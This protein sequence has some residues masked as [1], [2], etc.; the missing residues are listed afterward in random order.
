MSSHVVGQS[1]EGEGSISAPSKIVAVAF[2][3]RRPRMAATSRKLRRKRPSSIVSKPTLGKKRLVVVRCAAPRARARPSAFFVVEPFG[4]PATPARSRWRAHVPKNSC[5][6]KRCVKVLAAFTFRK[7]GSRVRSAPGLRLF[8]R[9]LSR[10][11]F[12]PSRVVRVCLWVWMVVR[13]VCVIRVPVC[14]RVRP[15]VPCVPCAS[16]VRPGSPVSFYRYSC[17]SGS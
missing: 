7:G 17:V 15:C 6:I 14:A 9:L 4:R 16:R 11:W 3:A 1:A 5:Q 13:F 8:L 12:R 10:P 2:S